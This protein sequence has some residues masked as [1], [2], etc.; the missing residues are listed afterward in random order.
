MCNNA[1]LL[2]K[3]MEQFDV[4]SRIL[5]GGSQGIH[6]IYSKTYTRIPKTP[7]PEHH[8]LIANELVSVQPLGAPSNMLHYLDYKY[9]N[10]TV[11]NDGTIVLKT[12]R[13]RKSKLIIL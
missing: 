5:N 1:F 6:P 4:R 3:T 9:P 8:G 12:K 13:N 11:Y 10:H 2:G 7:R